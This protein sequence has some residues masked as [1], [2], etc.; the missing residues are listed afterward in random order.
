[1]AV[2]PGQWPHGM[3]WVAAYIHSKG[4]LAGIYTDAGANG[5]GGGN[6]ASYGHYQQDVDAFATWG[7]DAIK[8]DNSGETA[9]QA[10]PRLLYRQFAEAIAQEEP[11]RKMLLNACNPLAPGQ[12]AGTIPSDVNSAFDNWSWAPALAPS[13]RVSYDIGH[14]GAVHFLASFTTSRRRPHTPKWSA[15]AISRT[16]TTSCLIR[17]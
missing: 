10:G 2:D 11:R 12:W 6:Q 17:E 15:A 7:F 3:Q 14:P 5:C 16:R 13:W 4:L 8:L 9:T 1:M